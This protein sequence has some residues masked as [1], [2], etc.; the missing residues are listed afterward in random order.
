MGNG[1]AGGPGGG[2]KASCFALGDVLR[3]REVRGA[4]FSVPVAGWLAMFG[5]VVE[6]VADVEAGLLVEA[7]SVG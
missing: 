3:L 5:E 1:W 7:S 6:G 2:G 4:A